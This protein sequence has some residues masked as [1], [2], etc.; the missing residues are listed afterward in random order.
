MKKK[1]IKVANFLRNNKHIEEV[2]YVGFEDHPDYETTKKQST[3]F[4]GM[5]SFRVIPWKM[6]IKY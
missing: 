2:Y 6:L 3:G 1:A 5:I 4:G